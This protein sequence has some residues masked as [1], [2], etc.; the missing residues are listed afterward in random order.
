MDA[1]DAEAA[2][3]AFAKADAEGNWQTL[4]RHKN[5]HTKTSAPASTTTLPNITE[6]M[7][8]ATKGRS[9][10]EDGRRAKFLPTSFDTVRKLYYSTATSGHQPEPIQPTP[11]RLADDNSRNFTPKMW[12]TS[13]KTSTRSIA[14]ATAQFEEW[15]ALSAV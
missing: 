10:L 9:T 7:N 8:A 11:V 6:R 12:A 14:A 1:K 4:Q 15:P 3:A 13:P 5:H 2:K